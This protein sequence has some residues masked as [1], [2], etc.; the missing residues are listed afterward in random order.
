MSEYTAPVKEISFVL[1]ELAG[2]AEVC[3]LPR[4]EECNQEMVAAIL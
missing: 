4:F 2:L 3:L 1:N